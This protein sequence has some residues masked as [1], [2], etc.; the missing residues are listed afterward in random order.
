MTKKSRRRPHRTPPLKLYWCSTQ[1]HAAD[2]FV[3]AHRRI[4]ATRFF[5]DRAGYDEGEVSAELVLV[6]SDEFHD[7]QYRG[8]AEAELLRACGATFVRSETPRVAEL[9][10][11]RYSEGMLDHRIR[12]ISGE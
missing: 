5:R 6:L 1:D 4:Q 11:V 3:V 9:Q 2:W 10:G 7:D 12:E 8:W